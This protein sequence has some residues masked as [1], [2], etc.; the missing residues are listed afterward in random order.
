LIGIFSLF[1]ISIY[2]ISG[3]HIQRIFLKENPIIDIDIEEKKALEYLNYI[4]VNTGLS[5]LKKKF[6]S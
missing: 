2:L 3:A 6:I 1:S 4:R 5:A